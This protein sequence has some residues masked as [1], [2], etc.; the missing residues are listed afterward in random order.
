M[1]RWSTPP[2]R[3]SSAPAVRA[4][5]LGALRWYWRLEAIVSTLIAGQRL[6]PPLRALLAVALHQLEY[7]RN[8]P[9]VIVSSAVDAA[10]LLQQARAAGLVNALLRRFL[11]ER[12]ALL[13]RSQRDP[14]A[15]CAHPAWLLQVLRTEWP[16]H[17]QQIIDANNEHP[18]MSLRV[19]TSRITRAAY[20]E[21]LAAGGQS[22]RAVT[23]LPGALVLDKPVAVSELPGFSE[24]WVSVQDAGAQLACALLGVRPGE[25]VLDACA[26][27]GGKTR[28][29]ARGLDGDIEL[30][31]VDIDD[32]RMQRIAQNL[33][34][35]H[36][37]AQLVTA[38]LREDPRWWDGQ[39]VRSH[40]G[41]CAVLGHRRH[42]AP[43]RHQVAA[44]AR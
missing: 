22:A 34:R 11:R 17:W 10:R 2:H 3:P 32:A 20:L 29:A 9:E 21:R 8:P 28:R 13:A 6:S 14:A 43:S 24:G 18:P 27:P 39:G 1:T 26:A 19:D 44:P 4:V 42:P 16:Q 33:Q 41:R 37:Q 12:D 30:T 36:R 40:P 31:A 35:L 5:T 15:A 23:W 38:D 7:S 25:R